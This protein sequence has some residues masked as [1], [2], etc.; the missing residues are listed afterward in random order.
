MQDYD[1]TH[2]YVRQLN[3]VKFGSTKSLRFSPAGVRLDSLPVFV[4]VMPSYYSLP[5]G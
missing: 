2:V 4:R 5:V 3:E 1:P